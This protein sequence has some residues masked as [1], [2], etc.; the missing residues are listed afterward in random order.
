MKN[1]LLLSIHHQW[2]KVTGSCC[3]ETWQSTQNDE[4]QAVVCAFI[5]VSE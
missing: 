4:Q 1:T 2:A 3:D 5:I